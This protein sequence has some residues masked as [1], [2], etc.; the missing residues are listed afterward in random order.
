MYDKSERFDATTVSSLRGHSCPR[1]PNRV[2]GAI[3]ISGYIIRQNILFVL[4][5]GHSVIPFPAILEF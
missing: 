1:I 2:A 5:G 3:A 4:S